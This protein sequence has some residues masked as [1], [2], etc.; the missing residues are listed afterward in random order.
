MSRSGFSIRQGRVTRVEE[1]GCWVEFA[2]QRCA[3]CTGHCGQRF[4]DDQ[5]LWIEYA[6]P[7]LPL[8]S[9]VEVGV[10]RSG[11]SRVVLMLLGVPTVALIATAIA[12]RALDP[13]A[14]QATLAATGL[15]VFVVLLLL[16]ARIA[17]RTSSALAPSII[18]APIAPG[19]VRLLNNRTLLRS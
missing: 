7:V 6:G 19:A 17:A 8:G 15:A 9:V 13:L 2:R 5:L 3:N 4:S 14:T 1:R 18:S 12:H 11:L 10:P 16:L